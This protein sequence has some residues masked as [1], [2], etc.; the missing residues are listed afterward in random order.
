MKRILFLDYRFHMKTKSSQFIIE[1]LKTWASV[2]VFFYKGNS[3]FIEKMEELQDKEYDFFICWQ[4][5]PSDFILEAV[6][7]QKGVLFPMYDAVV[8]MSDEGWARFRNFLIINFSSTLHKEL[9]K[10]GFHSKYIQYF[11]NPREVENW[12]KGDSL[13]FW[14][15]RDELPSEYILKLCGG[16]EALKRVHIHRAVDPGQSMPKIF[17]APE[18]CIGLEI[19]Y[20]DWF[21]KREDVQSLISKSSYYAASRRYEGIGMSFLEAMALG[22]CVIAPDSPTMNEYIINGETGLLYD[23]QNPVLLQEFD[24]EKIQKNTYEYMRE[25]YRKW[26][27][28]RFRILGWLDEWIRCPQSSAPKRSMPTVDIEKKKYRAYFNLLNKWV[29]LKK[30][31]I[32]LATYFENEKIETLAIY[33]MG[34]IAHRLQEEL[35]GAALKISY[36]ID[37]KADMMKGKTHIP[38]YSPDDNLPDVDAIVVTPFYSFAPIYL[39]L[40]KMINCRII[41]ISDVLDYFM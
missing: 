8:G 41:S 31:G 15:R 22:R 24:T 23:Y 14:Q 2:D 10:K 11:P 1:L 16:L 27:K 18:S 39:K 12:G 6:H 29:F 33:G 5:M 25:G 4:A 34:E 19:E 26:E 40:R 13:F 17:S 36:L 20:S 38:I 9:L 35:S 7:Y 30:R 37:Q 21:E 32:F 3:D 28:D